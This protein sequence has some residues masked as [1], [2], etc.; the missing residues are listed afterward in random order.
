MIFYHGTTDILSIGRYLL[1][2]SE[3]GRLREYWRKNNQDW[4]FATTSLKS[5]LGFAYK[6]CA[7]YGGNP[8]VYRVKP[9]G[10]YSRTGGVE[11]IMRK[12]LIEQ[13]VTFT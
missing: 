4:V 1:P 12:A 11:Y 10:L 2:A 5:A 3:T 8:V 9:I 13:E 7:V 6:A